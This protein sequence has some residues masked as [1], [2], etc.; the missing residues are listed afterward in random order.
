MTLVLHAVWS[1]AAQLC[2]WGEDPD[3][4]AGAPR[5]RTSKAARKHP[6][7]A[8]RDLLEIELPALG[9]GAPAPPARRLTILLPTSAAS[10][11]GSPP[12][13]VLRPAEP[14]AA[15]R[16]AATALEPWYMDALAFEPSQAIDV[17]LALARVDSPSQPRVSDSVAWT[18]KVVELALEVVG[19]GRALP[20]VVLAKAGRA[21]SAGDASA[22]GR[23]RAVLGEGDLSRLRAL[24]AAMPPLCGAEVSTPRS[25]RPTGGAWVLRGLFE[26]SVDAV[27]RAGLAGRRLGPAR[28]GKR[29]AA[30]PSAA[31]AWLDALVSDDPTFSAGAAELSKLA[32]A[33]A[34][35]RA[36]ASVVTGPVRTCLRLNEAV[37]ETD[38]WRLEIMLQAVEDPSL[39]VPAARVWQGGDAL[40]VLDGVV[41]HPQE[42]LLEGLG[43]ASR[44]CPVLER[45]LS[46]AAPEEIELDLPEAAAF[47][48]DSVPLLEQGGFAV[49]VP[50]WWRRSRL[51]MR[52][53]AKTKKASTTGSGLLGMDAICDYRWEVALGDDKLS[54]TDLRRLSKLKE[55]L[56]RVKGQWVELGAD[57]LAAALAVMTGKERAG[58]MDAG[59]VLR[60]AL[61]LGLGELAPG[62]GAPT[63]LGVVGV[64]ADGWLGDL[65]DGALDRKLEPM[66]TPV[67]FA[68]ELR[69]YQQRGLAWLSFM[70]SLG[71]GACLAD[72]MGLGK[73]AQLLALLVAE[74]EGR[75]GAGNGP[76]V[77]TRGRRAGP[78][79]SP[80][81][82]ICPM[83]LVGNWQREA[84]RFAPELVVHVH[85]GA[86]RL[87]GAELA[88]VTGRS[89]LVLTTYSLVARDAEVLGALRWGRIALDEAQNIKNS[90][91]RQTQAV[92]RLVAAQ[93]VALTGTPVENRLV[94]L[95][96]IM[97]FLNPG[98]LGSE[99]VFR[100]RFAVP[101]ER[102]GDDEAAGT[103]RRV[104]EPFI[105]R[106]LKTDRSI[107]ADLPDKLEMKV[108]CNLTREQATLYQAVVDNM[109]AKVDEAEGIE[110]RGLVLA[111][112]MKLKQVCNHPA[113][114][115]GDGSRLEG[116]SGKLARLVETLEEI[117]AEGDRALVFTQFAEMGTMLARHL[118]ERLGR[119]V[120]WLHGGVPKAAR[121]EMVE[122]F[123]GAG[124]PSVFLLSI[125]AGGTGLNLT[126]ANHVIHF[127]RWWNPAV[128]DQATDRAFRIGQRRDVQVRKLVCVG[129]L[130][131]RIDEM[132]ESKR[133][134][135]E[136]IVGTG[137]GWLTELSTEALRSVVALSADAVAEG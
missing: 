56:V 119:E 117:V 110:R 91:A 127:D 83:S 45:A 71:L 4:Q 66:R 64:E 63:G 97:S 108:Y 48:R 92:R 126:A 46:L 135:A 32:G 16:P 26:A 2:V 8:S 111:T 31:E 33:V 99:Q 96:S 44:L 75:P 11:I 124:G 52:L 23:W 98:L 78:Y 122:R 53:R 133:A 128:E 77:G 58:E 30:G 60:A 130:E 109:L 86:G 50:P 116:R 100:E 81:L 13:Q 107:I 39:L 41:E 14:R 28:R 7:G 3:L 90:G 76:G 137:E 104:T 114:L 21:G 29:L 54:V 93:R 22:Q 115:L 89:D 6:F 70:G 73:T 84:Q 40:K 51:G 120:A 80:T 113:Q 68:G 103:L 15:G 102:Y 47:L 101:I 112:M 131:E 36:S 61:G 25:G 34:E 38:P 49:L 17:A 74:R 10:P 59:S 9:L 55:P 18:A 79:S 57:E 94:E 134:L 12:C 19:R 5:A 69:P 95:W 88:E 67:G 82:V 43:K 121:D 72:D 129:T 106:R 105:L 65:L 123:Q 87:S 42:R 136:R 62:L 35:W 118:R 37:G 85:H 27:I 125:K 132:I 20:D 24:A 1:A